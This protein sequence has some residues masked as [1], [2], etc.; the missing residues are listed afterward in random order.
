MDLL[1]AGVGSAVKKDKTKKKKK[2]NQNVENHKIEILG[3]GGTPDKQYDNG[4]T[5]G[6]VMLKGIGIGPPVLPCT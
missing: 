2:S 6:R 3:V 5:A 1:G 4:P